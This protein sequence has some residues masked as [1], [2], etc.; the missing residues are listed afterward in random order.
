MPHLRWLILLLCIAVIAGVPNASAQSTDTKWYEI[1][2]II[3]ARNAD[4]RGQT[5]EWPQ[6]PFTAD[7][8]DATPIMPQTTPEIGTIGAPE[9]S[10]TQAQINI[11]PTSEYQLTGAKRRLDRTANRLQP[12]L[13]L[14]W[15]QPTVSRDK[16]EWFYLQVPFENL[17]HSSTMSTTGGMAPRLEGGIKVSRSRYLHIDLDLL[18]R[19]ISPQNEVSTE[20]YDSLSYSPFLQ[21]RMQAHRRMRSKELHYIDHPLMGV[22]VQITPY[23]AP[24]PEPIATP[25]TAETRIGP[26]DTTPASTPDT[27]QPTPTQP[28]RPSE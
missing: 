27:D 2:L 6:E 11:V 28:V 14:A 21:Y 22:L 23:E 13:H 8:S 15:R 18:L 17:D 1:E 25:P 7:W 16:A 24:E 10:K 12:L 20:Y 26:T 4:D 3:F 9:I 19:E 5:E